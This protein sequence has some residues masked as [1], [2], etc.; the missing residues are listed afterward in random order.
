[1]KSHLAIDVNLSGIRFTKMN[2]DFIVSE[3]SFSFTEKTENR[4]TAQLKQFWEQLNW[5]EAEFQDVSLSWSEYKSILV[6]MNVFNESNKSAIFKLAYQQ[7][8]EHDAIDYNRLP[9]HQMVHVFSIPAWIKSFFILR[10]PRI[11]IQHEGTMVVN[12]ILDSQSFKLKATLIVHEQH[13][14]LALVKENKLQFYST[15]E[16]SAIEDVI[17]YLSFTLKQLGFEQSDCIVELVS[18]TAVDFDFDNLKKQL[19]QVNFTED[20]IYIRTDLLTKF[21]RLCV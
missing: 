10:F 18:G 2:G 13:F 7:S 1:M 14:L 21:H 3:K 19:I 12:G 11:V 16:W 15:F 9:L 20:L 5:N 6:P 4:Y 17:Y 8:D